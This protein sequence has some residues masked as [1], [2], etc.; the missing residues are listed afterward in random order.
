MNARKTLEV[1]KA[2]YNLYELKFTGGGKVPA[3]LAGKYSSEREAVAARDTFYEGKL[4]Q[5]R[6]K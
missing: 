3:Y 6:K 4:N 1:R 5:A 2:P